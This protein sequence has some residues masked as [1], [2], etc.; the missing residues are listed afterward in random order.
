MRED[1]RSMV[2]MKIFHH[3]V[4]HIKDVTDIR[5]KEQKETL[6]TKS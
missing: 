1:Q 2:L 3:P 4:E 6:N 5:N